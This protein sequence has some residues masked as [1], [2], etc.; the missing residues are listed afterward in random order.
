[1]CWM[2]LPIFRVSAAIALTLSASLSM[3]IALAEV[4]VSS[5]QEQTARVRVGD[6]VQ[7]DDSK[8]T[9]T[10]KAV[11]RDSRCPKGVRRI[12]AGEAVIVAGVAWR[13]W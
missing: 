11:T 10:F 6:M 9:L 1:M 8:A 2:E 5:V 3:S 7:I 12:R 4:R 13:K